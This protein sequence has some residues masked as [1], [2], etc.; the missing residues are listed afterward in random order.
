VTITG[1][2]YL[3]PDYVGVGTNDHTGG[4]FIGGGAG[5]NNDGGTGAYVM[6]GGT[7]N[8]GYIEVGHAGYGTFTQTGGTVN[9][10]GIM[11]ANA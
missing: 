3:N 9:A 10:G 2:A 5:Q 6:N 4:L 1:A 11:F 7:L 8:A